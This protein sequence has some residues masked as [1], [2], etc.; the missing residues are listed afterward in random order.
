MNNWSTCANKTYHYIDI[1][2]MSKPPID[3]LFVHVSCI[4]HKTH[5]QAII[6]MHQQNKTKYVIICGKPLVERDYKLDDRNV[7]YLN[8]C[9]KYEGLSEKIICA[10]HAILHIPQFANITHMLKVDDDNIYVSADVIKSL[11]M[12]RNLNVISTCHYVGQRIN[13]GRPDR[14]WHFGKV[15]KSSIW[16]N[17]PYIG[18]HVPWLDGGCSYLLSRKAMSIINSRYNFSNINEIRRQSIYEDLFVSI[19]LR[20]YQIYPVQINYDITGDK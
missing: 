10:I 17:T 4:K 16:H 15:S 2:N 12:P 11:H 5:W 18:P 6:D 3:V 13:S 20:R 8:C 7:L 1:D 19:I 9:D 14:R